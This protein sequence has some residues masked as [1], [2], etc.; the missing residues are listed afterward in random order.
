MY[1]AGYKSAGAGGKAAQFEDSNLKSRA[2]FKDAADAFVC[3][4]PKSSLVTVCS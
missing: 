2:S 3:H 1:L 4:L